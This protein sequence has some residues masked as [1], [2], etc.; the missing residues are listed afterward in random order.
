MVVLS[1]VQNGF[2]LLHIARKCKRL[3][4]LIVVTDRTEKH[5]T[6]RQTNIEENFSS[7]RK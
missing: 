7:N 3:Y 6:E 5:Q 2:L 4:M 1:S